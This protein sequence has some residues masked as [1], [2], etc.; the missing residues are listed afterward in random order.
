MRPFSQ[1]LALAGIAAF[2]LCA[3]SSGGGGSSSGGGAT[4]TLPTANAGAAQSIN[5]GVTVTL[6]GS[7]SSDSDGSIA[8]YAWT[9]TS[10]SAVTLSSTTT[11]QP[12]FTAPAVTTAAT[13]TFSLVVTDNRGA[14]SAPATVN[15]TVNPVGNLPPAAN[16]GA[17]QTVN[18]G[19][20][21]TLDGAGS[22]DPDGTIASYTWVQTLGSAVTLSNSGAA[23]PSFTAPTVT[24]AT[25]LAFSLVV[26]DNQGASSPSSTV[27]ITVN[28]LVAGNVNVTGRVRFARVN[29]NASSPFGLNYGAPLLQPSRGVIVRALNASTQDVLATGTT[30]DTGDYSLTV[31]ANTNVIIRVVAQ[32]LR[33]ASQPLPRWNM[34]VQDG[35]AGT[36][37]SF[38]SPTINS[39]AGATR[40]V[41]IPTG[42]NAS[43]QATGTRA[44][45]PF[46]ILDTINAAMQTILGAAPTTNFPALIVDWGSQS[47]GTFFSSNGNQHIALLADLSEDTDEFDQHVVAHEFGHYIEFN[48]SRADNIGGSHGLGDRLDA[49]VAFGEGFGYAFAAIVLNDPIARDSFVNAGTQ[50]SGGFNI[51]TNPPGPNDPNGCWCSES[52]VWS[53]LYDIHDSA[54]DGNDSL[55]LG[56]QPIWNVLVNPQRVTPAFTTIFSFIAALKAA[57]PANA[58]AINTL[59]AAQNINATNID[60]F[61]TTETH[62][63]A[64]VPMN[65]ALPLYST[66]TFGVP[67]VLRTVNDAGTTNKVGNHRYIRFDVASTRNVTINLSSSNTNNPDPDFVVWRAGTFV[68][69]GIDPPQ[70]T[71]TETFSATPGTYIIDAYDC[72]NGCN[73]SEGTAGDYDLTVTIN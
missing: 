32:M 24:S 45:A 25:T 22:S 62:V 5:A 73:P 61:A 43:G 15:I 33:D 38:D 58:G 72:A 3:C 52:S 13:L 44:S 26:T 64:N 49:R 60:A 31:A 51:E 68:R 53:I 21:T 54:A 65:A 57:L 29:F 66:A 27:N 67:L 48:F 14:A 47:E 59:V 36:P 46:A 18:S 50:V 41:D 56:F 40:N 37:Y 28:P 70:A 16:A 20:L 11:A 8:S 9:Q 19:A 10:G 69:A 55:A 17:A 4:N 30:N 63:P 34:R 35:V 2:L 23:Q 7:A 42:I 6:N 1:G 71:E 39:G 12:T